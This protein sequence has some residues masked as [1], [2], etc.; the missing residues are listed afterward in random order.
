LFHRVIRASGPKAALAA[1]EHVSQKAH[2]LIFGHGLLCQNDTSPHQPNGALCHA[3]QSKARAQQ[4][5][6]QGLSAI[7]A[8]SLRGCVRAGCWCAVQARFTKIT[9]KT[10]KKLGVCKTQSL[11][12][13]S[14]KPGLL[15]VAGPSARWPPHCL[16][17][18]I[19]G[20]II[21]IL[22]PTILHTAI[23]L[24]TTDHAHER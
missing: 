9:F 6:T 14:S 19:T 22:H 11:G 2:S 12:V 8:N 23:Q 7:V 15:A 13:S 17:S 3:N 24:R 16:P 18:Q 10:D 5:P 20:H 4:L 1:A 21:R